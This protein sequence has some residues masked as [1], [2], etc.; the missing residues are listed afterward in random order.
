[1]THSEIDADILTLYI[2]IVFGEQGRIEPYECQKG[3]G[4]IQG[5]VSIYEGDSEN[6]TVGRTVTRL[7]TATRLPWGRSSPKSFSL[8]RLLSLSLVLPSYL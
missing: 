2:R 1:M 3:R 4:G 6:Q 7:W 8:L 5:R